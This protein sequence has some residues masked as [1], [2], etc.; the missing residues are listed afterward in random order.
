MA[1]RARSAQAKSED[2]A[3]TEDVEAQLAQLRDK[4]VSVHTVT[5]RM[6]RLKAS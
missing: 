2:D 4:G 1:T 6:F 3:A 5:P